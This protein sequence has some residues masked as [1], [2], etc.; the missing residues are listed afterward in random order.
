M[1]KKYCA[2]VLGGA[3][4]IGSQIAAFYLENG[5]DVTIVDALCPRTGGDTENIK[6]IRKDVCFM[7]T[8]ID[9]IAG[10]S[11]LISKADTVIDTMGWTL[12]RMALH[13]PL[14]DMRLN[15]EAH[16]VFINAIPPDYKG[17][18]V[19]LGS[20]GQYGSTGYDMI[21]EETPMIPEDVQGIHKTAAESHLRLAA[22]LNNTEIVSIRFPNCFGENQPFKGEDIGLIRWFY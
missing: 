15:L 3:G 1:D 18:I 2:L 11:G 8:E 19:Y 10:L 16:I 21:T 5:W 13:D 7:H 12:H 22:R 4:F 14:Y 6:K 17:Q 20:R 9:Q